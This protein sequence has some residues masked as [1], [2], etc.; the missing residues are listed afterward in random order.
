MIV[1][2]KILKLT[3]NFSITFKSEQQQ[4]DDGLVA[5]SAKKNKTSAM[6]E[7]PAPLEFECTICPKQFKY[8]CYYK[9]HMEACHSECPKYACEKCGKS[10]KWEAS[11]RQHL[12]S[13]HGINDDSTSSGP[14]DTTAN[15]LQ[16]QTQQMMTSQ[17]LQHVIST[18]AAA[19][20]LPIV[21][22]E[23]NDVSLDSSSNQDSISDTRDETEQPD[24]Q[25]E[26]L[27]ENDIHD[28]QDQI[29]NSQN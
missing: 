17:L 16:Q 10:Y 22:S 25:D 15:Q 14:L 6:G 1:K 7:S 29:D 20:T 8:Y 28:I 12:R 26:T 5:R 21:K 2:L 23:A 19:N 3:N 27:N 4:N 11:F 9:R 24:T 18:V 13:R